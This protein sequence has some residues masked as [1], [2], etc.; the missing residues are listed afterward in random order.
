MRQMRRRLPA[1]ARRIA[2]ENVCE[3]LR[4][5][6]W[7]QRSRTIAVYIAAKHELP[8]RPIVELI[9]RCRK[10]CVVPILSPLNDRRLWFAPLTR[11]S[12]L[13]LNRY[14]IP[15]PHCPPRQRLG[16]GQLDLVLAPLVL[17]DAAGHRVGMGGGFYDRTFAFLRHRRHWFKPRIVGI[18]YEFQRVDV[19]VPNPW[20]LPMD[21]IITD[22]RIYEIKRPKP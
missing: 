14:R 6:P 7:F 10:T 20:D 17:F 3:H 18:A 2:A 9:W 4:R 11:D 19:I 15:E 22:Q 13:S 21:G 12:R 1:E 5:S 8:T 16:P